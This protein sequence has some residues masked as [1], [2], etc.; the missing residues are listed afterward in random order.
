MILY[1]YSHYKLLYSIQRLRHIQH[2]GSDIFYSLDND[3]SI[4]LSSIDNKEI[5]KQL[6]LMH[7][8]VKGINC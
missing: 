2:L 3:L 8:Q 1:L 7:K 4:T 6:I 5:K